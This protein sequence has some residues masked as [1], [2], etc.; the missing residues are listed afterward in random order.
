VR[1]RRAEAAALLLL[2]RLP[3]V[4]DRAVL[5]LRDRFGSA[6]AALSAPRSPF[7]ALAGAGAADARADPELRRRVEEAVHRATELGARI[8]LH[9]E[10]AYPE[11]L[12]ELDDPP[13]VVFLRG[14]PALLNGPAVAVVGSRR[15]TAYGRRTAVALGAALA[16]AGVAVVSGLALGVD[17]SAHEGAIAAGGRTFAVLGSGIDR[18]Y[19]RANRGLFRTLAREHLLV[20]EFLPGEAPLPHHFP[21]RNRILAALSRAVIVVEAARRSGALITAEHATDLGRDVLAV[22]GPV[23]SPTSRGANELLRDGA[24]VVVDPDDP[25]AFLPWLERTPAG[26]AAGPTEPGPELGRDA[27]TLWTSLG[28]RP[29]T[30]AELGRRSE[31]SPPRVL[32]ALSLLEVEGWAALHPG[33]TYARRG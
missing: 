11:R 23:D 27:L 14:N 15:A 21:K 32:A 9:G 26:G 1:A 31:L 2:A 20:S 18:P 22:P 24:G 19:P 30:L 5:A 28:R 25:S 7:L 4:G 29:A 13:P 10:P 12:L 33:M 3:G 6:R 16:R 17:G 8:L